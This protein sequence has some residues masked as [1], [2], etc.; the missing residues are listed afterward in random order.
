M[1]SKFLKVKCKCGSEQN[2]FSHTTQVVK[3]NSCNEAL[4]HPSGGRAVIHGEIVE[5]LG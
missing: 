5:E 3:C 2:V 1:D 4:A